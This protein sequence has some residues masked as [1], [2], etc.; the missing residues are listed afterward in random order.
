M[1]CFVYPLT[2]PL[3]SIKETG[4]QTPRR[5]FLGRLVHHLLSQLA[6]H[7]KLFILAPKFLSRFIDLSGSEQY[8]IE[9]GDITLLFSR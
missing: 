9:L 1:T 5:W 2:S 8:E 4:I 3:C 7:I 6:F